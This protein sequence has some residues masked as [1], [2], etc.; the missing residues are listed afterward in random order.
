MD[1][2]DGEADFEGRLRDKLNSEYN[3]RVILTTASL[4]VAILNMKNKK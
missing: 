1:S 4:V 3:E 2:Y